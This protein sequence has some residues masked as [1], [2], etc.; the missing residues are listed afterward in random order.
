MTS[1]ERK[2]RTKYVLELIQKGRAIRLSSIALHINSSERTVRRAINQL[3]KEGIEIKYCRKER[4][5]V[6]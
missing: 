6:V 4:R 5:Y 1:P 2:A 3:R